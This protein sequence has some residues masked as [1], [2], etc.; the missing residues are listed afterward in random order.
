MKRSQN[1]EIVHKSIHLCRTAIG[2]RFSG[3]WQRDEKL[4]PTDQPCERWSPFY[5]SHT[6]THIT[7]HRQCHC[8]G[9]SL[10]LT[11]SVNAQRAMADVV[12]ARNANVYFLIAKSEIG[13]GRWIRAD[14]I[15]DVICRL[16]EWNFAQLSL[17]R[18]HGNAPSNRIAYHAVADAADSQCSIIICNSH[19][20]RCLSLLIGN[21]P[22][23][24]RQ[25]DVSLE[26]NQRCRNCIKIFNI[27]FSFAWITIARRL[28]YSGW[29]WRAFRTRRPY[30]RIRILPTFFCVSAWLF[31]T[32]FPVV[33]VMIRLDVGWAWTSY[34][35]CRSFVSIVQTQ[36]RAEAQ[37]IGQRKFA[38]THVHSTRV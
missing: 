9:F 23:M 18:F 10:T 2:Y 24:C 20:H 15:G 3:Q 29:E 35:H 31:E 14:R 22:F 38:Q 13:V 25:R 34:T 28:I 8:I 33:R 21:A 12:A 7:R 36:G 4:M 16:R 6:H 32:A 27:P 26:P 30:E 19:R 37:C 5:P 17:V 11:C 1:A